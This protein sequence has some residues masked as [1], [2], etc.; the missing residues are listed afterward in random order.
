MRIKRIES[1]GHKGA[2]WGVDFDQPLIYLR[3]PN[4]AGKSRTLEAFA[5]AQTG[6]HPTAGTGDAPTSSGEPILRQAAGD[7]SLSRVVWVDGD[8]RI[9]RV[10]R[11]WKRSTKLVKGEEQIKYPRPKLIV[12]TFDGKI[13]RDLKEGDAYLQKTFGDFDLFSGETLTGSKATSNARREVL[14]RY[15]RSDWDAARIWREAA[16]FELDEET[17]RA[18]FERPDGQTQYGFREPAGNVVEWMRTMHKA[19]RDIAKWDNVAAKSAEK[20]LDE[21]EGDTIDGHEVATLA[22]ALDE[23]KAQRQA[24]ADK[25]ATEIQAAVAAREQ[26][27]AANAKR[28]ELQARLDGLNAQLAKVDPARDAEQIASLRQRIASGPAVIGQIQ[29]DLATA[30]QEAAVAQEKAETARAARTSAQ[31]DAQAADGDYQAAAAGVNGTERTGDV[32][33]ASYDLQRIVDII[34]TAEAAWSKARCTLCGFE[35][36]DHDDALRYGEV[37]LAELE[38]AD[39]AAA[40]RARTK[41]KRVA[42]LLAE[43]TAAKAEAT[44]ADVVVK[45]AEKAESDTLRIL[46]S[47]T[48]QLRKARAH[49]DTL[50]AELATVESRATGSDGGDRLRAEAATVAE[51]IATLPEVIADDLTGARL[52][53]LRSTAADDS[54]AFETAE[55][56]ATRD[57]RTGDR[58]LQRKQDS[59]SMRARTIEAQ[60]WADRSKRARDA[61]SPTGLQERVLLAGLDGFVAG[62]DGCLPESMRPFRVSL[63]DGRGSPDCV[64]SAQARGGRRDIGS[65]S[66]GERGPVWAAVIAGARAHASCPWK[67]VTLDNME[68]VSYQNRMALFTALS[69]VH[70]DGHL[71]QVVAMGCADS[72]DCPAGWTVVDEGR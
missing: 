17:V 40:Q 23:L 4:G 53:T 13:I 49:L 21:L 46:R 65:L 2:R 57:L 36:P 35:I 63:V 69:A 72:P 47:T 61:F 64:F 55:A 28:I 27:G 67:G 24:A 68:G 12:E 6:R 3:A 52:D 39:E 45:A 71:T 8:G 34:E 43:A 66:Q 50:Q 48:E 14:F 58:R 25:A 54:A 33:D 62:V 9:A 59:E 10:T 51:Q 56:K 44:A 30:T 20:A 60:Q 11:S 16:A 19:L 1:E 70:S 15:M 31:A 41:A 22:A 18:I 5:M 26:A 7:S 32:D 29:A 38:A 42:R 37:R